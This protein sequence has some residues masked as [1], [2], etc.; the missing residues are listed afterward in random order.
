M[1]PLTYPTLP[2]PPSLPWPNPHPLVA[3]AAHPFPPHL[4]TMQNWGALGWRQSPRCSKAA[5]PLQTW[6]LAGMLPSAP[7]RVVNGQV[8]WELYFQGQLEDHRIPV[9]GLDAADIS[10]QL[11]APTSTS[12]MPATAFF[13]CL[14]LLN[15]LQKEV[16]AIHL[17]SRRVWE[18]EPSAVVVS[19]RTAGCS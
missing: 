7:I 19:M 6:H 17:P 3:H 14:P 16:Q 13:S 11:N 2:C 12:L 10:S 4:P 18:A 9:P 5:I 15:Y 1:P 8:C